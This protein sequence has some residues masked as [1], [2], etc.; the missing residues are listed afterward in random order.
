MTLDEYL[1]RPGAPTLADFAK[2]AGINMTGLCH[3]RAGRR[4]WTVHNALAVE[5]A[6]GFVLDAGE[7][8][9]EVKAA[10]DSERALV[11]DWLRG[12]IDWGPYLGFTKA[13]AAEIEKGAHFAAV[14][15]QVRP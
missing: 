7:L 1:T 6:S 11:L 4:G 13:V 15:E 14:R 2:Q 3:L 5:R 9:D 12:G 10:R 8:S